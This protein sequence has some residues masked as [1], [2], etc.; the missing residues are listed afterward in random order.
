MQS[1]RKNTCPGTTNPLHMQDKEMITSIL[2]A[3]L[4]CI[5]LI[6]ILYI[7]GAIITAILA[8]VSLI[9]ESYYRHSQIKRR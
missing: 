6:I 2:I 1:H 4:G 9:K 7:V 3:I 5:I 8:V